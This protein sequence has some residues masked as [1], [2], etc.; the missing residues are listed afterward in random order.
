MVL[1]FKM[2]VMRKANS[3][4][5]RTNYY[6]IGIVSQP[7]L[8]VSHRLL[9]YRRKPDIMCITAGSAAVNGSHYTGRSR[10]PASPAVRKCYS[11][12]H[13]TGGG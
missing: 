3:E 4:N 2:V 11:I 7:I 5:Q 9:L 12:V 1:W 13:D 10:A 6:R 8:G